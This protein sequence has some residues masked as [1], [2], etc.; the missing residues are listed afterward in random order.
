MEKHS[1]TEASVDKA[2]KAVKAG[3]LPGVAIDIADDESATKTEVE[4][5]TRVLGCNPRSEKTFNSGR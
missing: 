2:K 4:E 3:S 5:R 1:N